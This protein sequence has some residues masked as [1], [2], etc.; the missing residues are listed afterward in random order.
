MPSLECCFGRVD[1]PV[2]MVTNYLIIAD[3]ISYSLNEWEEYV[4][5]Q[6]HTPTKMQCGMCLAFHSISTFEK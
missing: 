6:S 5:T 4:S 1:C 2:T 3:H